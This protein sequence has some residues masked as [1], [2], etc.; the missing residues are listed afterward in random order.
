MSEQIGAI[1][2]MILFV[3]LVIGIL[4]KRMNQIE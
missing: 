1:A 4:S 2:I 3:I